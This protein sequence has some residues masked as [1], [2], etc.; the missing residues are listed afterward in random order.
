[1][2]YTGIFNVTSI[3]TECVNAYL[4]F[5]IEFYECLTIDLS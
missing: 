4:E 3:F 2:L 5:Y 1:V